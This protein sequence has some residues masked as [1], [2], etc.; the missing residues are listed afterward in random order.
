MNASTSKR[1]AATSTS[2]RRRR[3][4]RRSGS[5]G[6]APRVAWLWLLHLGL[7]PIAPEILEPKQAHH[8]GEGA[9][10]PDKVLVDGAF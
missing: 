3:G 6:Q 5:F 10:V 9:S 4:E 2:P 8:N 1:L 7:P